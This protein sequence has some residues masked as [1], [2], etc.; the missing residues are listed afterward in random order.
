MVELRWA[1]DRDGLRYDGWSSSEV[2]A[3][4]VASSR[5]SISHANEGV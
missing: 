2:G 4:A 1:M 5:Q 3:V